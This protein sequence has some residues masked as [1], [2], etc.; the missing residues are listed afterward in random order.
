MAAKL[1]GM[2]RSWADDPEPDEDGALLQRWQAG[3]ASAGQRLA[4]RY[5]AAVRRFFDARLPNQA[6][7]LTQKTFLAC[8]EGIAA[9]PLRHS[10]RAYLFGVARRRVLGELRTGYQRRNASVLDGP[11]DE[12]HRTSLTGVLARS[13]EQHFVL[14]AFSTLPPELQFTVQLFYWEAMPVAE[15]AEVTEVAVSTVTTRLAR[16]RERMR[17]A[18]EGLRLPRG[19]ETSVVGNLEGWTRSLVAGRSGTRRS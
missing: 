1:D 14:R 6:E 18:V 15:I 11:A 8:F 5:Y 4:D 10:F 12:L 7:D 3:D 9:H 17:E 13:Q 16:A 2:G 19:V